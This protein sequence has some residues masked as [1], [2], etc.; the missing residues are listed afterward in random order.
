M[1]GRSKGRGQS[2]VDGEDCLG[3]GITQEETT[4]TNPKNTAGALTTDTKDRDAQKE[5][6]RIQKVGKKRKELTFRDTLTYCDHKEK[7]GM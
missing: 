5:S 2:E 7:E 3:G 1:V 4:Q 6:P